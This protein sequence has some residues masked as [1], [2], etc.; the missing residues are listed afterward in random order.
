MKKNTHSAMSVLV[1]V[2]ASAI[3]PS[4]ALAANATAKAGLAQAQQIAK[5][6]Q[7]DA[8]LTRVGTPGAQPDGTARLWQYDFRSPKTGGCARIMIIAGTKSQTK[9]YPRCSTRKP[10]STNFIDSP[11]AIAE[12]RKSGFK[13]GDVISVILDRR[14]DNAIR[15][16][17]CW[18]VSSDYDFDEKKSVIRGWCVDPKTGKFVARLAGEWGGKKK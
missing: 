5:K 1:A 11:A 18:A 6:W 14:R 10:I 8:V 2:I 3:S 16:R 9:A 4:I 13:P 7:A 17:E 15:E 12:A